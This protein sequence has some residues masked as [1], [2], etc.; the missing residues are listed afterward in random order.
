[1][2]GTVI[3]LIKQPTA[4]LRSAKEQV[5]RNPQKKKVKKDEESKKLDVSGVELFGEEDESVPVYD[6]CDEVQRK[7][8]AYL[9][10]PNVTQAAFLRELARAL[11]DPTAKLQSKQLKDFQSKKGALEGNTSRIYYCAYVFFEKRRIQ[12]GKPKTKKREEN[13]DVWAA[14]GGIDIKRRR[15]RVLCFAGDTPYTD[16]WGKTRIVGR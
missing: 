15:D 7:I 12:Q 8:G 13:E 3:R 5:S 16:K 4:F 2:L 11:P 1:M 14:E 10:E 9:R 6:T